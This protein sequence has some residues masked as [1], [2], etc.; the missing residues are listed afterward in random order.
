MLFMNS[1]AFFD[2]FSEEQAPPVQS[3]GHQEPAGVLAVGV[4]ERGQSGVEG[5]VGRPAIFQVC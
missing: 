5:L 4:E 3:G 2:L 1:L